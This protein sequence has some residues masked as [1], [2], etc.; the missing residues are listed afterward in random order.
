MGQR[1]QLLRDKCEEEKKGRKLQ[2]EVVQLGR[3]LTELK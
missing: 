1:D 2:V 3:E